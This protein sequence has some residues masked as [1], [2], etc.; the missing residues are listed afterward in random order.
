MKIHV[1]GRF[2]RLF[3]LAVLSLGAA[4]QA[5]AIPVTYEFSTG[6]IFSAA[7]FAGPNPGLLNAF[8]GL[9][10]SGSFTYDSDVPQTSTTNGP[11]VFGQLNYLNAITD[12]EATI[13]AFSIAQS[14][15]GGG[16]VA[17]EGFNNTS[18]FFQAGAF[19]D[20]IVL[21]DLSLRLINARFFWVE[22]QFLQG[23][24]TPIQDFLNDSSLPATLPSFAGRF[25]LDFLS[26]T[27]PQDNPAAFNF[28]LFDGFVATPA[29][30]TVAEPGIL[31]L[32]VGGGLALLF[33][34][35]R[36]R[37]LRIRS[38]RSN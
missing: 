27:L 30:I 37:A 36:R 4:H 12:F 23:A 34:A 19:S 1:A 24:T 15:E 32:I 35:T 26:T 11:I 5:G 6:P 38:G 10:V 31:S 18:D 14:G 28:A 22:G 17:N 20:G 13:G 16:S 33:V 29:P 21:A 2:T 25:G 7:S 3:S 8:S 9:T